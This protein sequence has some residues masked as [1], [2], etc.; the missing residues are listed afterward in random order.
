MIIIRKGVADLDI[1]IPSGLNFLF[2]LPLVKLLVT[3]VSKTN[4]P[5]MKEKK[6]A[7]KERLPKKKLICLIWPRPGTE[8]QVTADDFSPFPDLWRLSQY[9]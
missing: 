8:V 1:Y 2:F 4:N 3:Q 6:K 5:Q 9:G 7:N